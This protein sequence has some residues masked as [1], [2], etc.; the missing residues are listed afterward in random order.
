MTHLLDASVVV[1][2][3]VEDHVHHERAHRWLDRHAAFS[4]SP[5]T[6]G[7]LI[8]FLVRGGLSGSEAV[9]VLASLTRLPGHQFW[10][11][12]LGY[13]GIS[14]KGVIGHRQ[15]TDAYLAGLARA[16]DGRVATL[17]RGLAHLHPDVADLVPE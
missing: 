8:R 11:D 2:L 5:S 4:T 1:A 7:S 12:R 9:E 6:Q 13:A 3:M 14:V 16:N 17:D 15:V 10:P